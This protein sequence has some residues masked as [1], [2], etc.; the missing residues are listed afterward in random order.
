M[1]NSPCRLD[2]G[3][4]LEDIMYNESKEWCKNRHTSVDIYVTMYGDVIYGI[5]RNSWRRC[6][7][8]RE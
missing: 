4:Q 6:L 3:Q 8:W 7:I 2:F 5:D 1:C